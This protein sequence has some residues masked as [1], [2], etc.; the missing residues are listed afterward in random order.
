[1]FTICEHF[2]FFSFFSYSSLNEMGASFLFPLSIYYVDVD[3]NRFVIILVEYSE[4][5]S[6]FSCLY[7]EHMIC[8]MVFCSLHVLFD[9]RVRSFGK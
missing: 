9:T 1:M 2:T 3:K 8:L 7:D 4:D 5:A 6:L